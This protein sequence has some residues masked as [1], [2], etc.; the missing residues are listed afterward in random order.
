V[1]RKH[2]C[3]PP[4]DNFYSVQPGYAGITQN[5]DKIPCEFPD[6]VLTRRLT[7]ERSYGTKVLRAFRGALQL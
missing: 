5:V 1:V 6:R 3:W 2:G 4:E 7:A